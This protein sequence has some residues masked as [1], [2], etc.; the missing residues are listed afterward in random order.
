MKNYLFP[1]ALLLVAAACAP[2][3]S[4]TSETA[5]APATETAAA[6]F[7]VRHV[8]ANGAAT[9]LADNEDAIVLD[10]RTP[11]EFAQGHI[12]GAINVNFFD[13]DFEQ[14][15]AQ[16]DTSE[17]YLLHCRSGGRSTKSL[18]ILERAG[19]TDVVHLDGGFQAWKKAG[20]QVTR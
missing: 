2:A 13:E 1:A 9:F 6:S 7:Q 18:P 8:D 20:Q 12:E 19:F 15:L 14:Q 5:A 17:T 10:V 11:K 4:Q 3:S 16:L